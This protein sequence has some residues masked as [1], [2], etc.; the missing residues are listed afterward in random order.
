MNPPTPISDDIFAAFL[1]CRYKAY[2]KLAGQAGEPSD[3]ERLQAR[4]TQL[5]RA[6]AQR[7][8]TEGLD[9]ATALQSPPSLAEAL[10]SGQEALVD[11]TL[12]DDGESARLDAVRRAPG[13]RE[14]AAAVYEPI[15]FVR[16]ERV[17]RDDKLR[18]AFA[19]SI[20]A[21]V[22][23]MPSAVGR[24]VHGSGFATTRVQL[25]LLAE[26]LKKAADQIKGI[27]AGGKPPP[28]IL[29][30]HCAECEFRSRCHAAAVEKDDL[31]LLGG[32]KPK[33]ITALNHK[34]I[35]TVMQYSHTFRRR[36]KMKKRH[37]A[38]LQALAVREGKVYVAQRP[39]LPAAPTL[40][41]LD[42]EGLPDLGFHY[43]VGLVV[44]QG[45]SR[46]SMQFWADDEAGE[47][48]IWH[49]FLQAAA[50]W[51][52][53]VIFH[54]G[55]YEARFLKQMA[56][57]HGGDSALL[58]R[59]GEKAVNVLSLIYAQV[60]FPAYS[61]DLKSVSACLGFRWSV[62][63]A[64][65]MQSV[66]WRH[67]WEEGRDDGLKQRLLTYNEE[68]CLALERVVGSLRAISTDAAGG[69]ITLVEDI[70]RFPHSS[71]GQ[72]R[73]RPCR[74]RPH[75]QV[76]VLRLPPR[77]GP[78]PHQ[79]CGEE[80]RSV[81]T[82]GRGNRSCRST[83]RCSAAVRPPVRSAARPG[84]TRTRNTRRSSSTSSSPA[85]A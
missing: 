13:T 20:L 36:K 85:G 61:N 3:Y 7:R 33:E 49:D 26:P 39:E 58:R 44:V 16:G 15:L 56:E 29:N 63:G 25:G 76:L 66:V 12:E 35:F 72:S 50:A 18:L 48:R 64:S 74:A 59:I 45:E 34:G 9:G 67:G 82:V 2:L 84:S 43:L 6:E 4:L 38:A 55:D 46:T 83:E 80:E 1:K 22:Q 47:A 65:G 23:G 75:H 71:F 21:R 51:P 31:S 32:L 60:Y 8:F 53:F 41:Y 57:R 40:V 14:P 78:L 79:P 11:V 5:Y 52:D 81:G 42:V 62:P 54:Y 27:A 37:D 73:H 69:R 19:A 17:G 77:E 10:R 28:L 24:I 70:P 30:R 68:D